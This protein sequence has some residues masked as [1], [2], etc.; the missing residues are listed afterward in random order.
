MM[1]ARITKLDKKRKAAEEKAL[2]EATAKMALENQLN[3]VKSKVKETTQS[4]QELKSKQPEKTRLAYIP[5]KAIPNVS[6][7]SSIDSKL[8]ETARDGRFIAYANGTVL[9]TKTNLVWAATDAGISHEYFSYAKT[10]C[11]QYNRGGFTDWRMPTLDELES[12]YDEK[13]NQ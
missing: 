12:L 11:E 13:K 7:A 4:I 5:K 9:D 10:Y 1:V 2:K 8:K 3:W 6:S